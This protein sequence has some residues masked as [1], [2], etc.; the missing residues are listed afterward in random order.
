MFHDGFCYI[1]GFVDYDR[2]DVWGWRAFFH[3]GGVGVVSCH[4]HFLLAVL[5]LTYEFVL[6]NF[7]GVLSC[8]NLYVKITY[9]IT[10]VMSAFYSLLKL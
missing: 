1:C 3:F 7:V 4:R 9:K 6:L 10:L 8:F 2:C 5:L